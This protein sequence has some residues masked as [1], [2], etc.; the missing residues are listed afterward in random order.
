[1][2]KDNNEGLIEAKELAKY[3]IN[4]S[5]SELSNLILQKTMYF[6]ELDYRKHNKGQR[7][8]KEDFEAWQYGPVVRNVYEEYRSYGSRY[9]EEADRPNMPHNVDTNIIDKTVDRC[10]D[11]ESWELVE[12]S[13]RRD[14]AWQ[15]TVNF[16]GSLGDTIS[17][18]LI[19]KE[20]EKY[21]RS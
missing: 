3:I 4:T 2:E 7:L 17:Q 14:G 16:G 5:P 9:I 8:I 20:A 19:A 15:K 10:S 1:M 21:G 11:R 13:H 12:E 18:D 6:V